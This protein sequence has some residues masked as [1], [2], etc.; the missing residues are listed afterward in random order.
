ML[1]GHI[2]RWGESVAGA[3]DAR[4]ANPPVDVTLPRADVPLRAVG[5]PVHAHHPVADIEQIDFAVIQKQTRPSAFLR[6]NHFG[7]E[8]GNGGLVEQ[9]LATEGGFDLLVGSTVFGRDSDFVV[10]HVD[11]SIDFD[12]PS[13]SRDPVLEVA[14]DPE[15][16]SVL[17]EVEWRSLGGDTDRFRSAVG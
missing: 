17:V 7:D 8:G 15:A 6:R 9:M 11:H 13:S 5:A 14:P 12:R 4:T 1:E 2:Q 10:V 3:E 16:V